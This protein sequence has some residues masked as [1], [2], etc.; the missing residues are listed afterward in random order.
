ME[1]KNWNGVQTI[2]DVW[3]SLLLDGVI[4]YK[5]LEQIQKLSLTEQQ[6]ELKKYDIYRKNRYLMI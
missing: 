2:D 5:E 6:K 3:Y 4:E 1:K